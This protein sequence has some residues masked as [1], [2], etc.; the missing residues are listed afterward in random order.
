MMLSGDSKV[1]NIC[2]ENGAV[3]LGK[4]PLKI[5]IVEG[6]AWVVHNSNDIF[7]DAGEQIDLDVSLYPIVISQL[8][9]N[10]VVV[11]NVEQM[12]TEKNLDLTPANIGQSII[13]L[14][15]FVTGLSNSLVIK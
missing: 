10:Q 5:E 1:R 9:K 4:G 8:H 12:C 3:N 15:S 6:C 14:K 13:G 11:F 7:I 2:L